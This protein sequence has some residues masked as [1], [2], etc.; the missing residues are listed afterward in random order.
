VMTMTAEA[1]VT[2]GR[3]DDL[4]VISTVV[5]AFEADP[6]ARWLY[7]D[8]R[9]YATY[10]PNFVQA[11][12]GKALMHASAHAIEGFAGTALWLPPGVEPDED[13]LGALLERSA[14]PE[15][16]DD[17]M[18]LFEQMGRSHPGEPHW[19]LPLI[20]VDPQY[21]GK[22]LGAA[23]LRHALGE[24]DRERLPAYLESSNPRNISLYRRHGF[25]VTGVIQAGSSPPI[26][27]MVREPLPTV[28]LSDN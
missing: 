18:S 25:E 26:Y 13:E 14:A 27:P 22:G 15:I 6:A 23:L 12:G 10:F 9:Q 4:R 19:Y 21:H 16:R 11:F 5:R 3:E 2:A 20:G 28:R 1:I 24:C 8:G 7:P 17:V